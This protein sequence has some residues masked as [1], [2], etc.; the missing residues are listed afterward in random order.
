MSGELTRIF[1]TELEARHAKPEARIL[2][3]FSRKKVKPPYKLVQSRIDVIDPC[4]VP[5]RPA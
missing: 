5:V 1:L 2:G 3:M 4:R